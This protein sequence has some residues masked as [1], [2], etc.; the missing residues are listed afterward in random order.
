MSRTDRDSLCKLPRLPRPLRK[1]YWPSRFSE[2]KEND[3]CRGSVDHQLYVEHPGS[4]QPL[5]SHWRD[6]V[7]PTN[8]SRGYW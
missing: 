7:L 6:S 3:R 5:Y 4:G 1:D 8:A 2:Q